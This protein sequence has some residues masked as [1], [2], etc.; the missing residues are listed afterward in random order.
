MGPL[1]VLVV[2]DDAIL[3]ELLTELLGELG[4]CVCAIEATEDGAVA[5]ATRHK[6]DLM[7][8]DAQLGR[9]GGL[10]AVEAI[11]RERPIAHVFVT[12]DIAKVLALRP[13]AVALQKPY[14]EAALVAAME[15]ALSA[16]HMKTLTGA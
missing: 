9:G 4:H 8:V 13:D 5:A 3:A 15:R 6:P 2:E 1:N 10:A 11:Q 7:I 14:N 16:P 12:G